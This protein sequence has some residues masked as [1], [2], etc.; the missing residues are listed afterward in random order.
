MEFVIKMDKT[1]LLYIVVMHKV[2]HFSDIYYYR[3]LFSSI[4]D[5]QLELNDDPPHSNGSLTQPRSPSVCNQVIAVNSEDGDILTLSNPFPTSKGKVEAWLAALKRAVTDSLRDMIREAMATSDGDDVISRVRNC[6]EW[7]LKYPAQVCNLA[8]HCHWTRD[9][10][11]AIINIANDRSAL[12]NTA[13]QFGFTHS[14]LAQVRLSKN[15]KGLRTALQF[16][17]LDAMIVQATYLRDQLESLARGRLKEITDFE[18]RK[19]TKLCLGQASNLRVHVLDFAFDYGYEFFS[20]A[21]YSRYQPLSE[22]SFISLSSALAQNYGSMIVK[23][24]CSAKTETLRSYSLN[25]G[26]HLVSFQCNDS[27]SC[28]LQSLSQLVKAAANDG[29]WCCFDSVQKLSSLGLRVLINHIQAVIQ[30]LRLSSE[31]FQVPGDNEKHNIKSGFATFLIGERDELATS[32]IS[33]VSSEIRALFRE[34]SIIR[35][36]SEVS[37]KLKCSRLGFKSPGLLG[38]KLKMLR[39]LLRD[40]LPADVENTLSISATNTVL[41]CAAIKK[42]SF[43]SLSPVVGLKRSRKATS[44]SAEG[45]KTNRSMMTNRQLPLVPAIVEEVKSPRLEERKPRGDRPMS[46]ATK[47]DQFLVAQTLVEI[48]GPRFSEKNSAI[49]NQL[50]R[51]LF[52]GVLETPSTLSTSRAGFRGVD[53]S[54]ELARIA[55]SRG[56]VAREAFTQKCTQLYTLSRAHQGIIVCGPPGCGKSAVILTLIET[57]NAS[58]GLSGGGVNGGG[59]SGGAAHG[60]GVTVAPHVTS[61][62]RLKKFYPLALDDP[63]SL[64]GHLNKSGEWVDGALTVAWKKALWS[65][66]T[67][68]ICLDGLLHASWMSAYTTVLDVS[69]VLTLS[70]GEQVPASN[71]IKLI[72]ET[73]NLS[74][75]SPSIISRSGI[76]YTDEQVVGWRAIAKAWLD[77]HKNSEVKFLQ[78]VFERSVDVLWQFVV[79][80]RKG[81]VQLTV[82]AQFKSCLGLLSAMLADNAGALGGEIHVERLFLFSLMWTIGGMLNTVQQKGFS[83][84]LYT[85]F[86]CM[87][88]DDRDICI[89]DYYVD[90]AGE[91]DP[92]LSRVPEV[93]SVTN[94]LENFLF[95]ETV[96]T[97]R[98]KMLLNFAIDA[99][100]NVLLIGPRWSGK[101]SLIRDFLGSRDQEEAVVKCLQYSGASYATQLHEF[102]ESNIYHRQGYVYGAK[103]NKKLQLLI[104]D[105]NLPSSDECGVQRPNELLRCLLGDQSISTRCKPYETRQIEGLSVIASMNTDSD[106]ARA[107]LS[108][109]PLALRLLRH[110][111]I[112]HLPLPDK[113]TIQ[114][115]IRYMLEA[116]TRGASLSADCRAALV[117]SSYDIILG[118]K[119]VLRYSPIPGREHYLFSL[120]DLSVC[121]ESFRFLS[122]ENFDNVEMVLS[123]WT[124]QIERVIKDRICRFSDVRWFEETLESVIEKYWPSVDHSTHPYYVTF[125]I[126]T[127]GDRQTVE[128]VTKGVV[129][130]Q[131]Y[132]S[133]TEVR[134]YSVMQLNAYNNVYG[135]VKLYVMLTDLSVV[136]IIR[137]HR[138]MSSRSKGHAVLVD[139]IGSKLDSLVRLTLYIAGYASHAIDSSTRD[140]LFDGLRS[141]LR[142]AGAEG[143]KITVCLSG[144]D[145]KDDRCIDAI[146]SILVSGFCPH[147]FSN[148][149]IEGLLSAVSSVVKRRRAKENIDLMDF[150]LSRVKDNLHIVVT[151]TAQHPLIRRAVN[152][153]PGFVNGCQWIWVGHWTREALQ[154]EAECFIEQHSNI[155]SLLSDEIGYDFFEDL[156]I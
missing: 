126:G 97:V 138:V 55:Q 30:A 81:A 111:T 15:A 135:N 46:P 77:E 52:P 148:N 22:R 147:I 10:E 8:L 66:V 85:L 99:G 141:A 19:V 68:W 125:P 114:D 127:N 62:H 4:S 136:H 44:R 132:E 123:L 24:S 5:I 25:M 105:I 58:N 140:G 116:N 23:E 27:T 39:G 102:I 131:P 93:R 7:S 43:R 6:E 109:S 115:I 91:W 86:K 63:S 11:T 130:L 61:G 146:N 41:Q 60:G 80:Q 121:F 134:D 36:D 59:V 48:I 51:D 88:D 14:R 113:N 64:F 49:F 110:F 154:G 21:Q 90:E 153:F 98:T 56:F 108:E 20:A 120:N 37:F 54:A 145:L 100:Q 101:R 26:R 34:V 40:Q 143:K 50:V 29:C 139:I 35:S 53:F 31:T 79:K 104:D 9:C 119:N 155:K 122:K 142:L 92:W 156:P 151:L 3:A 117:F 71:N 69:N 149:D 38:L 76:L 89:F 87:P 12:V 124:Y 107:I 94:P 150:L 28:N 96:H 133:L 78:R 73:T 2:I 129:N 137:L 17:R 72:F 65:D 106:E 18:W 103:D 144:K 13:K 33:R 45:V 75:A 47:N 1:L 57:L 118:C 32:P 112:F 83:D 16:I 82:V 70:N 95:V 152:V 128:H 74:Q 84:I 67:S 42:R